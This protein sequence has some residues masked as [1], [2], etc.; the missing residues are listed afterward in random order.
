MCE[1]PAPVLTKASAGDISHN[2]PTHNPI[3]LHVLTKQGRVYHWGCV[4]GVALE[5]R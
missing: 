5:G 2:G 4:G 3:E 1:V